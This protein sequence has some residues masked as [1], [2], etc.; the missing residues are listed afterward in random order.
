LTLQHD[1]AVERGSVEWLHAALYACVTGLSRSCTEGETVEVLAAW[2]DDDGLCVVYQYPYFDGVLGFRTGTELDTDNEMAL[3]APEFGQDIADFNIGEPL[4]S[5]VDHLR[6]D[7]YGVHWWGDL[8]DGLPQLP[9]S[10]R[11]T[12]VIVAARQEH[13]RRRAEKAAMPRHGHLARRSDASDE[14]MLVAKPFSETWF[15]SAAE[16]TAT[17]E[18]IRARF[19]LATLTRGGHWIFRT[20]APDP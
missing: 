6:Q 17:D 18:E 16:A 1:E 15:L 9:A 7:A 14:W 10:E 20:E 8:T 13:E 5:V 12:T 3:S 11:L 19:N 4:G 2:I